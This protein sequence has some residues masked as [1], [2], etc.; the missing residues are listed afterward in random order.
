[1]DKFPFYKIQLNLPANLF[2]ELAHSVDFEQFANGRKVGILLAMS[3]NKVPIVRTTSIYQKPAQQFAPIHRLIM[4]NIQTQ[5]AQMVD[6]EQDV[7]FNHAMLEIYTQQYFKMKYHSDQALDLAA[8]SYI[9]L[10]SCYE[11]PEKLPLGLRR[12]KIQAKNS[13]EEWGLDLEH[14][15]VILFS[16]QTNQ[17]YQHKIILEAQNRPNTQGVDNQW[18]GITF[19][20]S[21]TFVEFKNELPFFANGQPLTM[22]TETQIA[23][24]YKLKS[25]ENQQLN[26]NY[27]DIL[28]TISPSDMLPPK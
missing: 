20:Q 5:A 11:Q 8:N 4:E 18:L 9:A 12:L 25:T 24:F 19:R 23:E 1:M 26:Y 6:L 7:A 3:E 22:A 28:Y 2:A 14:N 10:F 15:S 21:K 27:T 17:D 16:T 13:E